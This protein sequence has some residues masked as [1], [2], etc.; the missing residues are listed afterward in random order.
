MRCQNVYDPMLPKYPV[1]Q[2]VL[3]GAL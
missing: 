3:T 2:S 1:I